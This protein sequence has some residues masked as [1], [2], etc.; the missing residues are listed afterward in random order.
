[1]F[2]RTQI[3]LL[4]AMP[5]LAVMLLNLPPSVAARFKR[6]VGAIFLPLFGA[7]RGAAAFMDHASYATLPRSA[8]VAELE[9]LHQE[10]QH[11]KIEAM[12]AASLLAETAGT[13]SRLLPTPQGWNFRPARVVAREPTTWWRSVTL[14]YGT[15]DGAAV[16]QPVVTTNGLVG[17][18]S[19][20]GYS[21][22]QVALVGDAGCGVSALVMETRDNGVI[23]GG[24]STLDL[25]LVEWTAMAPGQRVLAGQTLLTTG[26]GGVFPKGIPVG[27][28]LDT[29]P[30]RAATTTT[31]RVKL[32][33]NL[34]HLEVVFV[35]RRVEPPI[36]P[37][38]DRLEH[39]RKP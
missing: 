3:F 12:Q 22:S 34:D 37:P 15:R 18:I 11:L 5:V 2:K 26:L 25:G 24:Q 1:M 6:A 9:Q 21:H 23:L 28:I 19:S 16:D 27:R 32:A 10:N 35:I 30:E 13:S 7:T 39:F 14:D 31:A 17:R 38:T 4:V 29:R 33:A 36:P 8:L 20:A